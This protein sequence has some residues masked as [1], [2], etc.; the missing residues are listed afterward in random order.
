[1]KKIVSAFAIG[2]ALLSSGVGATTIGFEGVVSN[3]DAVIP[4]TPYTESGYMLTSQTDAASNGI[5]G[6]D[7]TSSNG[8]ATFVFC[9]YA[10]DCADGEF[11]SLTSVNGSPFSLSSISAGNWQ[12]EEI[13]GAI[14][15][16]GHLVGGGTV[17]ASVAAG[18]TWG[19]Y[20]LSGFDNLLGVDFYGRTVYA[21]AMDNLEVNTSANLPEP[22]SLA[23][24]GAGV[25]GVA[26]VRH[27]KA[28]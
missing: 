16:V 12:G 20:R 11:I 5:F 10:G 26:A 15:L 7:V 21:V 8:T 14:D 19:T 13:T 3:E 25:L 6:K 24:L 1:M 17:N 18:A 22:A 2:C 9:S 23:L 27:R 4:V 28:A